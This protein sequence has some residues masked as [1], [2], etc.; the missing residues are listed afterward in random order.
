MLFVGVCVSVRCQKNLASFTVCDVG[1]ETMPIFRVLSC[2]TWETKPLGSVAPPVCT[3]RLSCKSRCRLYRTVSVCL[4][5]NLASTFAEPMISFVGDVTVM[6]FPKGAVVVGT[7][8]ET[9]SKLPNQKKR[10]LTNGPPTVKPYSC[11]KNAARPQPSIVVSTPPEKLPEGQP[12][13]SVGV[14]DA[15]PSL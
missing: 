5:V 11:L 2:E 10:S 1:V 9:F 8:C 14:A 4:S 3:I 12:W 7:P 6:E 15:N 13:V